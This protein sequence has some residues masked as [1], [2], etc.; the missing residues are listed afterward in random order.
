MISRL[1]G[2]VVAGHE[3]SVEIERGG[4]VLEVFVPA[5]SLPALVGSTGEVELF[6]VFYLEGSPA[7]GNLT[8]RLLGF[9]NESD[10]AFF[11]LF[12]RVKGVSMRRALRAMQAP[13]HLI[14]AA[15]E[16][17]D[18]KFLTSLP[19]IGKKTAAQ[20]ITDL[21]GELH[22]FTAVAVGQTGRDASIPTL[23]DAQRLAL[24]IIVQWG[25]RRADAQ[26]WVAIAVEEDPTLAEPDAIVRAAYR[27]KQ[28]G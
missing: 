13:T 18:E 11:E 8:P 5:Y 10:R 20:I 16:R 9:V 7:G 24:D 6:T 23:S 2:R 14:A 3:H 4:L 12:T 21:R 28:R 26:Q 19:E 1:R 17:G 15:I 27:V 25:D 22:L